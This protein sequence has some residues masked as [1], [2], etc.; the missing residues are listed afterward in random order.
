MFKNLFPM[1]KN[2]LIVTILM[3]CVSSA[4]PQAIPNYLKQ[5]QRVAVKSATKRVDNEVDKKIDNTVNKGIDNVLNQ[6]MDEAE[7]K[8]DSIQKSQPVQTKKTKITTT[9]LQKQPNNAWET[10]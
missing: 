8:N 9:A 3:L 2:V 6:L 10:L 4:Y 1:K 7:G 5:K